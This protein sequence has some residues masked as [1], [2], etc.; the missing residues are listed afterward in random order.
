MRI[1]TE[2][3]KNLSQIRED[4]ERLLLESNTA[5]VFQTPA[6]VNAWQRHSRIRNNELGIKEQEVILGVYEKTEL[7]GVGVFELRGDEIVFG[8]MRPQWGNAYGLADFG[9]IV[10]QKGREQEVW[11]QILKHLRIAYNVSSIRLDFV[12]E[13][14]PSFAVLKT[15]GAVEEQEVSPIIDL[16]LS[17]NDYLYNLGRK[18]R[19]ELGRKMRHIEGKL[20]VKEEIMERDVNRLVELVRI[21]SA[22]KQ[23]FMTEEMDAFF[24]IMTVEMF[25]A[26]W[27]RLF[28]LEKDELQAAMVLGFEFKNSWYLYNGGYDPQMPSVG[29]VLFGLIIQSAIGKK[30][31]RVDFLRGDERYK[32]DL[33]AV[34]KKL[35]KMLLAK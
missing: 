1:I 13:E 10:V 31:S 33:G 32:Y 19:H 23:D 26:G 4:W 3:V 16:P 28:V 22:A 11:Q 34:D 17:W 30:I 35:F 29:V 6:W 25:G 7:V 21:S 27:G 14:S 9:D 20:V 15:V 2:V 8:A 24:R 18:R 5:T 12:R